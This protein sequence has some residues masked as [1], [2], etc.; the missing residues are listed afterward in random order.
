M[1]VIVLKFGGTS[2]ADINK[3]NN[4]ADIVEKQLNNNKLIVVLSAM[5]GVTNQLQNYIDEIKS[6]EKLGK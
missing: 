2:V 6:E 4:V 3:I 1:N 5:A